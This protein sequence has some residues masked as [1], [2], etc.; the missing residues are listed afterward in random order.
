MARK[1]VSE[2]PLV[3][4]PAAAAPA[5]ARRKSTTSRTSRRAVE[6][7]TNTG[8]AAPATAE[9]VAETA[10]AAAPSREEIARLAYSLWEARGH[11]GG[12]P[13]EDWLRAE[14]M[15]AASSAK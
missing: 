9:P 11:Q 8:F 10:V 15:L 14:Q 5:P 4:S 2:K 12:S 6:P 3:V 1:Q 7:A 13:E